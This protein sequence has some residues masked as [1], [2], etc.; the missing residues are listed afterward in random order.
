MA[1]YIRRRDLIVTL[2]G[3]A[4]PVIYPSSEISIL[5]PDK[6]KWPGLHPLC[7][8]DG[9]HFRAADNQRRDAICANMGRLPVHQLA[10]GASGH[11][12]RDPS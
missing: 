3:C 11:H 8:Q 9:A 1:I 5:E 7:W 12:E 2:G 4:R 10:S 6:A